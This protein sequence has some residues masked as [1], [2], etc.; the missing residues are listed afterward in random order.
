LTSA[1]QNAVAAAQNYLSIAGFSKQGL[2]DQLSSSAGDG[3]S[4]SDATV[5]V[6]SLTV[7]WNAQAVRAAKAYLQTSPFS[8]QDL[9][10]QL[11]SSAGDQYT[12][13]QA[14]YAATKVGIC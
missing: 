5:A 2:I 6:D 8:C 11:S 12:K 13:A 4:L 3:Y 9:V 10:Q 7:D 14:Q 1:Q